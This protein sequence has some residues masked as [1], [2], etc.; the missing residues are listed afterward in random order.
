MIRSATYIVALG[1]ACACNADD[2]DHY[3]AV[4]AWLYTAFMPENIESV[5][6]IRS[7]GTVLAERQRL[8]PSHDG[9][10]AVVRT[11][12]FE[13]L[14]I[15]ALTNLTDPH[16]AY[17]S[18]VE[19]TGPEWVLVNGLGVGSDTTKF[20]AQLGIKEGE[21]LRYCGINNCLVAEEAEGTIT[22]IT[23]CLYVD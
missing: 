8:V 22:K 18:G 16:K 20:R 2:L 7:L 1:F 13:N 3:E 14:Q 15:C 11:Y 21:G 4:D 17:V 6:G 9:V 12:I 10:G 19:I 23:I 5:S